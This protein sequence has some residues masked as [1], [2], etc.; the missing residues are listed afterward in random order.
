[1]SQVSMIEA[2]TYKA[3]FE[4]LIPIRRSVPTVNLKVLIFYTSK[5]G[6]CML[7]VRDLVRQ[8][9]NTVW[10]FFFYNVASMI[11]SVREK[12]VFLILYL[13]KWSVLCVNV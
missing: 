1:M 9:H 7:F 2:S 11:K 8:K 3:C 6:G 10:T 12:P 4:Y 5:Y 13:D